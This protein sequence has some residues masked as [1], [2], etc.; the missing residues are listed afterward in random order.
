[1]RETLACNIGKRVLEKTIQGRKYLV[2][3][4]SLIVPGVLN[5][6]KG[7]LLYP[8]EE[9]FRNSD[10]WNGMPMVANHPMSDEGKPLSGRDPQ[11]LEKAGLGT[12][13]NVRRSEKGKLVG[14]GWFDEAAVRKVAPHLLQNLKS[15][16]PIEISTGLFTNNIPVQP[17]ATH[18]G[19]PYK[20]IAKDYRPDHLAILIGQVGACSV[21]D[22]CGVFNAYNP[23]Q[24]RGSNGRWSSGGGGGSSKGSSRSPGAVMGGAGGVGGGA[25]SASSPGSASAGGSP[26]IEERKAKIEAHFAKGEKY[27][28]G[29]TKRELLNDLKKETAASTAKTSEALAKV[30]Q[31]GEAT[32]AKALKKM[33]KARDKHLEDPTPENKQKYDAAFKEYGDAS[34]KVHD[35][36]MEKSRTDKQNL[37][38]VPDTKEVEIAK[39][40]FRA[41][42][43]DENRS[44]LDKA[45][46][47]DA[48]AESL[49]DA[50]KAGAS[51]TPSQTSK[52]KKG[53]EFSGQ[54]VKQGVFTDSS[55]RRK[56]VTVDV[57]ENG[58]SSAPYTVGSY[59]KGFAGERVTTKVDGTH[60]F[61][62]KQDAQK[63]ANKTFDNEVAGFTG[64]AGGAAKAGAKPKPAQSPPSRPAQSASTQKTSVLDKDTADR[65]TGEI[66][67]GKKNLKTLSAKVN[68]AKKFSG[69][70][71]EEHK[72]LL[73]QK[74]QQKKEIER[75]QNA[76]DSAVIDRA[77]PEEKNVA[78]KQVAGPLRTQ[79]NREISMAK[80]M[81]DSSGGNMAVL[82]RE[83]EKLQQ[84]SGGKISK[85]AAHTFLTRNTEKETRMLERDTRKS[86]VK[87]LI[88]NCRCEE[89]SLPEHV[90][91][92][93][94]ILLHLSD[95]TLSRLASNG[96]GMPEEMKKKK[97]MPPTTTTEEDLPVDETEE[98]VPPTKGGKKK[99]AQ[100]PT[101]NAKGQTMDEFLA[102]APMELREIVANSQKIVARQKG[103]L[104]TRLTSHVADVER[105]KTLVA[106]LSSKT[107]DELTEMAELLPPAPV[108]NAQQFGSPLFFGQDSASATTNSGKSQPEEAPL[109]VANMDY[110][111]MGS[112][113]LKDY[114][115][116]KT[117]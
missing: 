107:V 66:A 39:R 20:F 27:M 99:M 83:M 84:A 112:S 62:T 43:S 28:E 41:L 100:T 73:A 4:V 19:V 45:L 115:G 105:K 7:P 104:I 2:A 5:G 74:R 59:P 103:E 89:G 116:R 3:P 65:L 50:A 35:A 32:Q 92:D 22:G 29:S 14:E 26:S 56:E 69:K 9:V 77:T 31:D 42:P 76:L 11:V 97:K 113:R 37:V 16:L 108:N 106:N 101:A 68:E 8:E 23:N 38:T 24:P 33:S 15:G 91:N 114:F 111:A 86:L 94:N 10:A 49:R 85:I 30:V 78:Q 51:S 82:R 13:Y 18:N 60:F 57:K 90:V 47:K 46:K 93:A 109:L 96:G 36:K 6:S 72:D 75:K 70:D 102:G 67:D 117:N 63:A 110:A 55:G 64:G 44:I 58:P 81:V 71:S 17:G 95:E 88:H 52:W 21:N 61:K 48:Q 40:N 98:G 87:S 53:D 79:F 1:M 34:Q 12:V 54:Q 80:L 25:P